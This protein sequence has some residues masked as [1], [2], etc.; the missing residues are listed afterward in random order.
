[1]NKIIFVKVYLEHSYI[2]LPFVN[3]S[4]A[5]N[6][7]EKYYSNERFQMMTEDE[8]AIETKLQGRAW[9]DCDNGMD[10]TSYH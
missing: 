5:Y 9:T 8:Y 2:I 10:E 3:F 6:F 1:M 4:Y 7:I